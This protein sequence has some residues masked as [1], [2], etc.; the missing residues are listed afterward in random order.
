M[1]I[2]IRN[3]EVSWLIPGD[4][5]GGARMRVALDPQLRLA[6]TPI[7]E[8]ELNT[9]CRDEI[10]PV[11]RALQHLYAQPE[12]RQQVLNL[13]GKDVNRHSSRKRGRRGMDYWHVIVLAAVRLGCNLDYDKLQDL[14][15]QHRALRQIMGIGDWEEQVRFDWRRIRDNLDWLRPE[16][17][18]RIN[19]LLV[20]AG[21]RLAPQA[22]ES[23]RGDSFVAETNIHYPSDSSLIGDGVRKIL[24]L[25]ADLAERVV[26]SGWRQ[27]RHLLRKARRLVGDVAKM[28]RSKGK[29]KIERVH[30]AYQPLFRFADEWIGRARQLEAQAARTVNVQVVSLRQQL[31]HFR[32][33]TEKV[34]GYSK[35]RVLD[36][37][38]IPNREKIF[39]WFEPHTELIRKGKVPNENQFGH[40][41]L[42]VED[43]V[44]FICAYQ[45]MPDGKQDREVVVP[46]MRS[47]QER[48]GGKIRTASFDRA[49]H[50]P[51]NQKDLAAIIHLPCVPMTG[52]NED[53]QKQEATIAFRQAR[54]NHSGVESAINALQA[55][56]GLKRCRDRSK[57]GFE[58]YVGLG[59]LGR[60][61]HV[62]GK[63]LL[64]REAR[65]SAAAKTKRLRRCA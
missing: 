17:L 5:R 19:E 27:H 37:A 28:A 62:L 49:F 6:S 31:Q 51:E 18:R 26:A 32:E 44:G 33:L 12:L 65:G 59:V 7:L 4:L 48:L 25:G 57:P 24:Q 1:L 13:V 30:A 11:L 35:R 63:V 9:G 42:I 29:N 39:S 52:A 38:V 21:H 2:G 34:C 14:A 60:N 3:L 50:S 10:I 64:A 45:V 46:A 47:L 8:V 53:G 15:E 20:A 58:R 43:G 23:V 36:G 22:A 54:Q 61:L 55:G 40:N 41:V 16:T 56:N